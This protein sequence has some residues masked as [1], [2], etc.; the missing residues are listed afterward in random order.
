MVTHTTELKQTRTY[1]YYDSVSK[2][3]ALLARG[4]VRPRFQYSYYYSCGR[5]SHFE[6]KRSKATYDMYEGNIYS[7]ILEEHYIKL[8]IFH[9]LDLRF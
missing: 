5:Y 4:A 8:F 6:S 2:N 3:A 7:F 1:T 9:V